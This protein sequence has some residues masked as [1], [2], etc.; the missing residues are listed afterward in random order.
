MNRFMI[1]FLLLA[2]IGATNHYN[3]DL[4][5]VFR[6]SPETPKAESSEPENTTIN[7]LLNVNSAEM[8]KAMENY[9]KNT[10]SGRAINEER[11]RISN[12]ILNQN[13]E[14]VEDI[15][16]SKGK[17][18]SELYAEEMQRRQERADKSFFRNLKRG[19]LSDRCYKRYGSNMK[20]L[21]D[22]I[23]RGSKYL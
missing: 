15:R 11:L 1:V 10:L 8:K 12:E 22:C 14:I 5:E 7:V 16:A 20:D 2:G 21:S 3:P 4:F 23:K 17:T 19:E 9:K 13:L 6:K 18:S